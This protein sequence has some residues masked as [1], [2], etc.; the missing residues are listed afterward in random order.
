[1]SWQSQPDCCKNKETAVHVANSMTQ[2][3]PASEH[4]SAYVS[5]RY[6]TSSYANIRQHTSA[7][8]KHTSAYVSIREHTEAYVSVRQAYYVSAYVSICCK[9]KQATPVDVYTSPTA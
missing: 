7:Y 8:V 6:H 4:T 1:M 5:I 3:P 2:L 9:R